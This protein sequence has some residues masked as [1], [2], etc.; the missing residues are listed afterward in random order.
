MLSRIV[1]AE[2]NAVCYG[3]F[4][5]VGCYCMWRKLHLFIYP[6]T[7]FVCFFL[8]TDMLSF[9]FIF[10]YLY[11]LFFFLSL[12]LLFI[13]LLL[14]TEGKSRNTIMLSYL[15]VKFSFS[16]LS[17]VYG[18]SNAGEWIFFFLMMSVG[19]VGSIQK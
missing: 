1:Y 3:M 10:I 19:V 9:T 4:P 17:L 8:F 11:R 5:N 13:Y 18:K 12:K 7:L 15:S 16:F 14:S 2:Q 6:R